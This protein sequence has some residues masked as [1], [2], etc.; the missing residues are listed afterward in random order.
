MSE[1]QWLSSSEQRAWVPLAALLFRLPAALDSQ[2]QREEDLT[3]AGY[4]VLA[5]LSELPDRSLR[6]SELAAAT[7]TT[8]SRISRVA[9]GLE[10]AGYLTRSVDPQDRRAVL[11]RLT[12]AGLEK[13]KAASPG[14]V[15]AVR[16]AIFDRL[17]PEQVDQLAAI[18]TSLVGED[19]TG[20]IDS[21]RPA[22]IARRGS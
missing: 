13:V 20:A 18:G 22:A 2:L 17:T 8:Q 7:S 11:A 15:Q 12:D 14:H 4:M 10:K 6:M 21:G 19:W 5:M 9:G 3:F 16:A 1:G